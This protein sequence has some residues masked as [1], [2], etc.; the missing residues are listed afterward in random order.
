MTEPTAA[1]KALR[2]A[3]ISCCCSCH[4]ATPGCGRCQVLHP[5]IDKAVRLARLEERENTMLDVAAA[6]AYCGGQTQLAVDGLF[7]A[8]RN[9]YREAAKEG[10]GE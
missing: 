4:Q 5:A 8:A 1:E 10:D 7:A 3:H 9:A 6:T 2:E